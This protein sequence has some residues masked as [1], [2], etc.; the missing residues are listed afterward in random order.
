MIRARF[1]APSA[2]LRELFA[3]ISF[4]IVCGNTDDHGRNDA[5]YVTM[6]GLRLT[7]AYDICPQARSGSAV[8]Q[9]MAYAPGGDRS[10]VA[11]KS[12]ARRHREMP[13]SWPAGTML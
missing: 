12:P 7:P 5:A 4:N 8:N 10:A 11:A 3:R 1:D 6:T 13:T 2:T 9:A